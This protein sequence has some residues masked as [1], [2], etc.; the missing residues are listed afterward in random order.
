MFILVAVQKS[1]LCGS[2]VPILIVRSNI[3]NGSDYHPLFYVINEDCMKTTLFYMY[4]LAIVDKIFLWL[5]CSNM[6][7]SVAVD[8]FT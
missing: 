6:N 5:Q 3:Y 2:N 1:N 8:M 7:M 4:Q